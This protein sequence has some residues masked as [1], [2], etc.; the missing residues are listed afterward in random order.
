MDLCTGQDRLTFKSKGVCKQSNDCIYDRPTCVEQCEYGYV[1]Y[2][3]YGCELG[4]GC[5]TT[6]PDGKPGFN[7]TVY[8][9]NLSFKLVRVETFY[10]VAGNGLKL[11]FNGSYRGRPITDGFFNLIDAGAEDELGNTYQLPSDQVGVVDFFRT[12]GTANFQVISLMPT[13]QPGYNFSIWVTTD[14]GTMALE[15]DRPMHPLDAAINN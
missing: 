13:I 5:V 15:Y 6:K 4:S 3:P 10:S 14:H 7:E 8:V 11:Y 1:E 12:K 2:C 9:G